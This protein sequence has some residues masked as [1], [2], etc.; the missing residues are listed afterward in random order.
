LSKE[1]HEQKAEAQRGKKRKLRE[2][3]EAKATQ[4]R[5]EM[6]KQSATMGIIEGQSRTRQDD[7]GNKGNP[8]KRQERRKEPATWD[9]HRHA[10]FP[11]PYLL[12]A[13]HPVHRQRQTI[14]PRPP[15]IIINHLMRSDPSSRIDSR[16]QPRLHAVEHRLC[17]VPFSSLSS[18][19]V[20]LAPFC[21][22]GL[23]ALALLRFC[24]TVLSTEC[25]CVA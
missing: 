12:D 15:R 24:S 21:L 7:K 5:K 11:S 20:F 8:Q 16:R 9:N 18:W 25:S 22:G 4:E 2:N 1:I 13:S 19:S 23:W 3:R 17:I 6:R 14:I 10:H